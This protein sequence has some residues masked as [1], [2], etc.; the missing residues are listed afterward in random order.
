MLASRLS[1]RSSAVRPMD[2]RGFGSAL[3]QAFAKRGTVERVELV[4]APGPAG[5]DRLDEALA[6]VAQATTHLEIVS[7]L[8]ANGVVVGDRDTLS[9]ALQRL[10]KDHDAQ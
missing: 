4:K 8:S 5:G 1:S 10:A 2:F 7:R 9:V 6:R 3:R